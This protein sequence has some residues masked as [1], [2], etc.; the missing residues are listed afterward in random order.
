MAKFNETQKYEA[1]IE[2]LNDSGV[3]EVRGI[4]LADLTDLC[5][6]KI[7][8][9]ANKAASTSSKVDPVK[10]AFR[11]DVLSALA[12]LA[13]PSTVTDI[14]KQPPLNAIVGLQNQKVSRYLNDLVDEGLVTKTV[15]KKQSLFALA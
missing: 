4:P 3:I 10:V 6:K 9:I 15:V 5:E 1:I 11:N 8:Q 13:N 14:M 7:A 2:V 12:N